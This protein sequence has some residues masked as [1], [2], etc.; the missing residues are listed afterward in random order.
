MGPGRSKGVGESSED[1]GMALFQ[2]IYMSSLLVPDQKA[3]E[4]ILAVAIEK[5]KKKEITGMMLYADGDIVQVLE[6]PKS[7]VEDTF[8]RILAD[9]RHTGLI[10]LLEEEIASRDFESWSMGYQRL[11]K[12]ELQQLGFGASVFEA[13][14]TE[15]EMRLRPGNAREVLKSFASGI[16]AR[17]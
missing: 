11:K 4:N 14:S 9:R 1:F 13:R 15:I 7:A 6:G 8:D 5:N 10:V 12:A 2:L 16:G 3:V 17:L